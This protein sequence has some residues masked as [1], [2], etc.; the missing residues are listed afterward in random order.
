[1]TDAELETRETFLRA[2]FD[3]PNDPTPRLIYADWLEE[4]GDEMAGGMRSYVPPLNGEMVLNDSSIF[5]RDRFRTHS[6]TAGIDWF[7]ASMAVVSQTS[8][9]DD[10][11]F[12]TL[13]TTAAARKVRIL[14]ADGLNGGDD[15]DVIRPVIS[16]AAVERLARHRFARKLTHLNLGFNDLGNDAARAIARS[17][18]L[19]NLKSLRL[20]PG[21]RIR[22]RVWQDVVARF[23]E[24]VVE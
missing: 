14:V 15:F 21:N 18:Y 5:L 4:R 6:V 8:V 22:G 20:S 17:P 9:Y 2:I 3:S 11:L 16:N 7:G 13:D 23:G 1:V 10:V 24:E 12:D 19:E